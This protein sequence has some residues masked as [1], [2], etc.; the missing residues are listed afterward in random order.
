[1]GMALLVLACNG[2]KI[3]EN[4]GFKMSEYFPQD[5]E[6]TASWVSEDTEVVERLTAEKFVEPI[7]Q[8]GVDVYTWNY[9]HRLDEE[10]TQIYTVDWA[11][12]T[13][14]GVQIY[15]YI[16]ADGNSTPFDPPIQVAPIT[17]YMNTGDILE[18]ET[19]G[20]TWTSE[21]LDVGTCEVE[22][23]TLVWESCLHL[24]IDDGDSND[25]ND[26]GFAGEYWQ[27]TTYGTA[28]FLPSGESKKWVL[29]DYDWVDTSQ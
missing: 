20:A 15:G 2:S 18:T 11:A 9:Y 26:P 21:I 8:N 1:M 29:Y 5:G 3:G 27:V 17:D 12:P 10:L 19:G 23:G 22:W 24:R 28:W 13:G 6:R 4:R 7:D 16:D 14:D 25:D